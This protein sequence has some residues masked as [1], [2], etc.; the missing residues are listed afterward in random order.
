MYKYFS[1]K[2]IITIGYD[3]QRKL[4]V[5]NFPLQ[6][7]VLQLRQIFQPFQQDGPPVRVQIFENGA[8]IGEAIYAII[9]FK[10]SNSAF[11][12]IQNLNG[13]I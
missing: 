11:N 2:I 9:V 12:A 10:A 3:E 5:T 1:S 4:F 7:R 8:S 6:W 13:S